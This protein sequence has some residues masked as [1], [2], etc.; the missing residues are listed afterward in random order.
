MAAMALTWLDPLLLTLVDGL[1]ARLPQRRPAR[2]ALLATRIISHRGERR[3][4]GVRENTF[5]A[6][7]PL[8]GRVF[9]LECDVRFTRDGQPVVYHDADLRRLFGEKERLAALSLTE[10]RAR[11]PDIPTLAELVTRYGGRIHLMIEFKAEPRPDPTGQRRALQAALAP[12]TP[13]RDYHLMSLDIPTL[14]WLRPAFP[15]ARVAIARGNTAAMSRYALAAGC[16]GMTGHYAL[17][18]RALIRRH[19]HAGQPTGV[20]FPDSRHALRYAINQ[21][22]RW[23]YT[24]EALSLQALLAADIAASSA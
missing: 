21:G 19:A 13:Q 18:R 15:S 16:V 24:N 1:F 3:A 7:D 23:I 8:P 2:E 11:H 10:L 20:G 14:D 5:A 4:L 9:G 6:F 22:S 17:L 12:L